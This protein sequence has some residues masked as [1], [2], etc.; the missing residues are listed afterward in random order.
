MGGHPGDRERRRTLLHHQP[1]NH[2]R[3]PLR[4]RDRPELHLDRVGHRG[5]QL[6][7]VLRL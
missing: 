6:V 1:R 2:C 5:T 7:G 4:Q 3:G